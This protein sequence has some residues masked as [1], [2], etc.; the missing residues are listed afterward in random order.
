MIQTVKGIDNN[1]KT[2]YNFRNHHRLVAKKCAWAM[3]KNIG[4][5]C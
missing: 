1:N 2:Y 3:V 5:V 4:S